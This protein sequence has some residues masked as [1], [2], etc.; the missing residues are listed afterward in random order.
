M[1]VKPFGREGK[2]LILMLL[3]L[4]AIVHTYSTGL[5][6]RV[7]YKY[8]PLHPKIG[9]LTT[10]LCV[11]CWLQL[12]IICEQ[13]RPDFSTWMLWNES[14][15]YWLSDIQISKMLQHIESYISVKTF[16]VFQCFQTIY[17][18]YLSACNAA[19]FFS[20]LLTQF[21]EIRLHLHHQQKSDYIQ[22]Y[23]TTTT[24]TTTINN[25]NNKREL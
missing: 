17:I 13:W 18:A 21:L 11:N 1:L 24:T 20:A 7:W 2:A 14:W 5:K 25:N 22:I 4:L 15:F 8:Q 6:L 16:N 12:C 19:V 23:T 3:C 10:L 9:M